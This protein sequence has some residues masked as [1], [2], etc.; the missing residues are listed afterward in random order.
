MLYDLAAYQEHVAPLREE[1]QTVL[2]ED[3]GK[4]RKSTMP[5]LRKLDSFMKES[6]RVNPPGLSKLPTSPS[7]FHQF[8]SPNCVR[9]H[10]NPLGQTRHYF[11]GRNHTTGGHIYCCL[12]R[13]SEYG[14]AD[15]GQ[16]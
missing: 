6:Q 13:L 14:S 10:C 1:L 11:L 8:I 16:S 4:F 15:M 2:S 7:T 9:S 12:C 5:K 3:G